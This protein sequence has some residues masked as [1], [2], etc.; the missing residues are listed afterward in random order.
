MTP[1]RR[2]VLGVI[3]IVAGTLLALFFLALL[4]IADC[5]GTCARRG[6]RAPA[7]ALVGAG[8]G[9]V[10]AGALV[11]RKGGREA[12]GIGFLA[13]GAAAAIIGILYVSLDAYAYGGWTLAAGLV[14]AILGGGLLRRQLH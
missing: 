8:L 1:R 2:F 9:L 3:L 7:F 12:F 10:L 4:G 11:S 5:T 6:E 13:M 14:A